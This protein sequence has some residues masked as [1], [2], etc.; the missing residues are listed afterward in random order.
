MGRGLELSVCGREIVMV[1]SLLVSLTRLGFGLIRVCPSA[2]FQSV[3]TRCLVMVVITELAL[4][5]RQA[6]GD[7]YVESWR[8]AFA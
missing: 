4:S 6:A 8:S 3:V 2:S 5:V 1:A 7:M